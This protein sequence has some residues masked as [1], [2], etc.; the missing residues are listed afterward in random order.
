[1]WQIMLILP[2]R[3]CSYT[4]T[5]CWS[6][7]L[8]RCCQ[9]LS[10]SPYLPPPALCLSITLVPP[11][12]FIHPSATSRWLSSRPVGVERPI[13]GLI[14]LRR[15]A[16]NTHF[17]GCQ[18][19]EGEQPCGTQRSISGIPSSG[20]RAGFKAVRATLSLF[21][22]PS[23]GTMVLLLNLPR[24]DLEVMFCVIR[25]FSHISIYVV[26]MWRNILL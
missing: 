12:S 9:L 26:L 10:K 2:Y 19:G 22:L 4:I 5:T 3:A 14:L 18:F 23:Q 24:I 20:N 11:I 25:Y 6:E 13:C 16:V 1:M 17:C 8:A 15:R 21:S 7:A